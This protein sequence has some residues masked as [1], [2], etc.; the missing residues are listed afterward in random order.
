MAD[1][2]VPLP[3]TTDL[4]TL[5]A[6]M[7]ANARESSEFGGGN[8][9]LYPGDATLAG[10]S[11]TDANGNVY[12]LDPVSSQLGSAFDGI[13]MGV[14]NINGTQMDALGGGGF[15]DAI[16]L[17]NGEALFENAKGNGWFSVD[18][19]HGLDDPGP[20]DASGVTPPPVDQTPPPADQVPP[21]VDQTPPSDDQTPPPVDQAPADDQ[22]PP[23]PADDQ[24]PPPPSDDGSSV[25]ANHFHH[26]HGDHMHFAHQSSQDQSPPSPSNDQTSPTVEE[27]PITAPSFNVADFMPASINS[28]HFGHQDAPSCHHHGSVD[29]TDVGAADVKAMISQD[30]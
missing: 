16:R 1:N 3:D 25:P 2:F 5:E 23:P 13:P 29:L 20:G 9:T 17:V 19:F 22:Q 21:P 18:N 8:I 11:V 26:A 10:G 30:A 4:A 12:T 27:S 28:L 24:T 6:A 15:V 14:V 7:N